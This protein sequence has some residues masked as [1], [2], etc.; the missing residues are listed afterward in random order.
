MTISLCA[1]ER[2]SSEPLCA[3]TSR[4]ASFTCA[5]TSAFW[6]TEVAEADNGRISIWSREATWARTRAVAPNPRPTRE[7]NRIRLRFRLILVRNTRSQNSTFAI[8]FP[9]HRYRCGRRETVAPNLCGTRLNVAD[10]PGNG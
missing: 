7:K 8:F 3:Q 2:A 5:V 1:D 4:R 10:A 6:Q 9:S